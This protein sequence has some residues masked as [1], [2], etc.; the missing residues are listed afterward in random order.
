[1]HDSNAIE[2]MSLQETLRRVLSCLESIE[3]LERLLKVKQ[4][5]QDSLEDVAE[6]EGLSSK[7]VSL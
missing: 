3:K 4:T 6:I 1:M 5:N 2:C 7:Y